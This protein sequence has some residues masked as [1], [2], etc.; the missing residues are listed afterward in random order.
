MADKRIDELEEA[1]TITATDLFVLEQ[2]ATAKKLSGQTLTAKLTELADGHGGIASISKTGTAGT[3]PI[4]DTYTIAF[5]DG[6][7]STFTVTN[8][9]KGDTGAQGPTGPQGESVTITSTSVQYQAWTSG[10]QY[11]TGNWVDNPPT[12]SQGNYLWTRTIV[13]YSDESQ[14]VSYSVSRMGVDGSGAVSTVNGVT[15]DGS[16]NIQ[17][18]ASDV[19]ALPSTY[20]A[21]V[22]SVNGKN[23]NVNLTPTD[24]AAVPVLGSDGFLYRSSNTIGQKELFKVLWE[25]ENGWSSGNITVN[26]LSDYSLFVVRI[27]NGSGVKY[28]SPLIGSYGEKDNGYETLTAWTMFVG[29]TNTLFHLYFNSTLSGNTLTLSRCDYIQGTSVSSGQKVWQ[30]VGVV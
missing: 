3:D 26:G 15:P 13:N 14:T 28:A 10:T 20:Q 5:A 25:D 11:P 24:V 23:G 6:S 29:G 16:G 7:T 1:T 18:T 30:I 17:L 19:G 12:V 4:V 2:A 9:L 22:I 21:P 27:M 8:G